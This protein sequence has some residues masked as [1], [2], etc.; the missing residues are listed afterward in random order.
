MSLIGGSFIN[1]SSV[2]TFVDSGDSL[3]L[4]KDEVDSGVILDILKSNSSVVPSLKVE[5]TGSGDA[6]IELK[7]SDASWSLG[8]DNDDSDLFK[9]SN[10]SALATSTYAIIGGNNLAIG[11][12]V[13]FHADADDCIAIGSNALNSTSGDANNNIGIGTNSLTACTTGSDNIAIGSESL[14]AEDTGT[15]NTAIGYQALY[16]QNYD[17]DGH[18]I[19]IGYQAMYTNTD[20]RWNIAIGNKA[21]YSADA[22]DYSNTAV[23][24]EAGYN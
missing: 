17:G 20:S 4:G 24:Y 10:S 5:Q 14:T 16:S 3:A 6:A 8:I 12:G 1:V 21:L 18:N 2:S 23:G 7:T 22:S 9:L 19:A 15:K 11:T 13:A